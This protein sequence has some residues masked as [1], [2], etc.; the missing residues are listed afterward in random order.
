MADWSQYFTQ[1]HEHYFKKLRW[2]DN[3][4]SS[5]EQM[6]HRP[7]FATLFARIISQTDLYHLQIST[8]IGLRKKW[9]IDTTEA[10]PYS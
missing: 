4:H 8:S 7:H 9:K 5:G 3:R 2:F 10:Y 1:S 6:P